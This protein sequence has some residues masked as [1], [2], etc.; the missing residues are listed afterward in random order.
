[1]NTTNFLTQK[2][3][4][5]K[6]EEIEIIVFGKGFGE[7]ILLHL[8]NCNWAIVDSFISPT[9]KRPVALDYLE[10]LGLD[11]QNIVKYLV[12]THW[13]DD[14]IRG[15]STIIRECP[16]AKLVC[17]SAFHEREF[18]KLIGL[19]ETH[20]IILDEGE[21]GA[22]EW[23]KI[24]EIFKQRKTSSTPHP[25][26]FASACKII[27]RNSDFEFMALSPSDA[28]FEK[29]LMSFGK[30]IPEIM[31]SKKRLS[32]VTPNDSAVV[33]WLD[34]EKIRI[35]LGAD[36]EVT[37]DQNRGWKAIINS[38]GRSAKKAEIY[39]IAHHGSKS[40][41]TKEI[42]DTL[43]VQNPYSILTPFSPSSLPQKSDVTRILKFT[44][45]GYSAHGRHPVKI[46]NREAMVARTQ[47]EGNIKIR[48]IEHKM[49]AYQIRFN[50]KNGEMNKKL[51]GSA[52]HLKNYFS[53]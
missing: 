23:T 52:T 27:E 2:I 20:Q 4:A 22:D 37:P 7:C 35:L 13:H 38:Q 44:Q 48:S 17:S 42:W 39:K 28:E 46:K 47:K 14:H 16:K 31:E 12:V 30:L 15:A 34:F 53:N 41:D 21:T 36:L 24:L 43:L 6:K 5:P 33:L 51:F 50:L 26:Y 40:S 45:N 8:G 3:S 49:G 10:A 1:M 32:Y 11:P 25:V 9:S 18:L 19:Q 29:S